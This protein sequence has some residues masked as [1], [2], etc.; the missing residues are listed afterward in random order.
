MKLCFLANADSIHSYRWVAYFAGRGH[1]VDWISLSPP[2]VAPLNGVRLHIV[3]CGPVGARHPVTV[4]RALWA[5]KRLVKD[6]EPDLLHAHYVGVNGLIAA[7]CGFHP[8]VMTAWG[9]DVLIAGRSRLTGPL[10][11]LALKRADLI[12]CDAEHMERTMVEMG[13]DKKRVALIYFGTDTH[14]FRRTERDEALAKRL[15]VQDSSV[16]ISV[17]S[18]KPIY[19]IATLLK[20]VPV[21]LR[22]VPGAKFLIGG[23]GPD[24]MMLRELAGS[25]GL[26]RNVDF[27]GVIPND[28]LV[29]Y[30]S[31][32]D[33]YVSTSLTDAG[34]AA[35]T[36]EAMS[37]ELPVVV[38]ESGENRLWVRDNING[39]I[40]PCGHDKELGE[41]ISLLLRD[42]ELRRSCGSRNRSV[43]RERNDFRKEMARMERCYSDLVA[44]RGGVTGHG[45]TLGDQIVSASRPPYWKRPFDVIGAI[46]LLLLLSPVL[47][48]IAAV[49]RV[50]QNSPVVF[51]QLRTGLR[52]ETFVLYK[53][54]TM[55][56]APSAACDHGND[57]ERLTKLGRWLRSTSLDELPELWNVLRGDMSMVGPRP[58]LP[59]YLPRYSAEQARRHEV[60]AG[61]TG[62]AQVNGRNILT[63]E[64][65]FRLDVWYVDN[66]SFL[67]DV[68]ILIRTLLAVIKR[69]G[70]RRPGHQTAAPF[71]GSEN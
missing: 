23:A 35:S 47:L 10:V 1:Q 21:V 53:F 17:R 22:S 15:Q 63:W 26:S 12:T 6:I 57:S 51:R 2:K 18:L 45:V 19:D 67:L 54:R 34:L 30:F 31:L 24:E 44:A 37:C 29:K 58:L 33:V 11:R 7:L 36:A 71:E 70:I 43:I 32:A 25:L 65:K 49:L 62:W 38:T 9:S 27:L 13:V 41:K 16:V 59:E 66:M 4:V 64:E 46:L 3:D 42:R 56:T 55:R 61:I 8:L 28:E 14:R 68:K 5:V 48:V 50:L 52:G 40:V 60:C 20:S 69:E 39:F